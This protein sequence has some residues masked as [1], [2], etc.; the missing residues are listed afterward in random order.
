MPSWKERARSLKRE[1]YALY[2]ACRDPR[3]PWH[4][5]ALAMLLVAYVFSP[6]DPIPDFIPVLGL[7][8]ELVVIPLGVMA[9]RTMVPE[10]VLAECRERARELESKPVSRMGAVLVITV[11]LALAAGGLWLFIEWLR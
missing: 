4:A 11:W 1:A 8:D 5:K 10:N 3:T 2:F 7:L 6:I 9:V